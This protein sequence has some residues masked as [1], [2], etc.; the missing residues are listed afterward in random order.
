[1]ERIVV[2]AG[3]IVLS[4]LMVGSA[5][6]T[7]IDAATSPQSP[8]HPDGSGAVQVIPSTVSQSAVG[9]VYDP[10]AQVIP[11][12]T[13][14]SLNPVCGFTGIPSPGCG[15]NPPALAF[16]SATWDNA[17]AD[18]YV[19]LFGGDDKSLNA[20]NG[21]YSWKLG[22]WSTIQVNGQTTS[23]GPAKAYNASIT[24]D[25][26][27]GYVLL[28]GGWKTTS[29]GGPLNQTYSFLSGVWTKRTTP[30]ALTPRSGSCLVWIPTVSGKGGYDLL[31]GGGSATALYS[32][33]WEYSGGTWTNITA[34][35]GSGPSARTN[36]ACAWNPATKKVDLFGGFAGKGDVLNDLW[37]FDP[38][39]GSVGTWSNLIANGTGGSP[40]PRQLASLVY[41]SSSD[42]TTGRMLLLGGGQGNQSFAP[43]QLNGGFSMWDLSGTTWANI[44]ALVGP[45]HAYLT[46]IYGVGSTYAYNYDYGW[47]YG[48]LGGTGNALANTVAEYGLVIKAT[49]SVQPFAPQ[50]NA[51][52]WVNAT[53]SGGTGTYNYNW[54]GYPDGCTGTGNTP[55]ILCVPTV[56]GTYN[57][58]VNITDSAGSPW[59]A[60]VSAPNATLVLPSP[61]PSTIVA[62][63]LSVGGPIGTHPASYFLGAA[64]SPSPVYGYNGGTY[65]AGTYVNS[66]N[67]GFSRVGGGG[68]GYNPI[69]NQ[70]W[71]APSGGGTYV[72]TGSQPYNLTQ[73][74]EWYASLSPT[75]PKQTWIYYLPAEQNNTSFAEYTAIWF[76]TVFGLAPQMWE[77]GNEPNSNPSGDWSHYG[78][79]F[80]AWSTTDDYSTTPQDYATMVKNY[81]IAVHALYPN[82]KF[83]ACECASVSATQL[84][85]LI[86]QDWSYVQAVAYHEYPALGSSSSPYGAIGAYYSSL[87]STGGI[88]NRMTEVRS[89]LTAQCA[90]NPT[91]LAL[92]IQIGEY[93]GGPASNLSTYNGLFQGAVWMAASLT[94]ALDYNVSSFQVFNIGSLTQPVA[95]K[96]AL[97]LPEGMLYQRILANM[98]FGA[99]YQANVTGSGIGTQSNFAI[100]TVN[101]SHTS[102]LVVNTNLTHIIAL[103]DGLSGPGS[104]Y[105]WDPALTVPVVTRYSSL[106]QVYQVPS[107]GVLLINNY[108]GASG[109]SGGGSSGSNPT[110]L[111]VLYVTAST[112]TLAWGASAP[113]SSYLVH[114]GTYCGS[115]VSSELVYGQSATVSDL[116]PFTV[117]CFAVSTTA[118]TVWSGSV[119]VR[120]LVLNIPVLPFKFPPFSPISAVVV[121]AAIGIGALGASVHRSSRY[122][123][124]TLLLIAVALFVWLLFVGA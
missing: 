86:A 40:Q 88:A 64:N 9:S 100:Q 105:L 22:N 90:G 36:A 70:N 120:T 21:T 8:T 65:P 14:P 10:Y 122:A 17:S 1:M 89:I 27:S 72:P 33:D 53:V 83:I 39:G 102:Q 25:G 41:D 77:F 37:A 117:Y 87:T 61:P 46:G 62:A 5:L 50:L 110:N 84:D 28:F 111:T 16:P 34:T 115:L 57:V 63:A 3:V 18:K 19:V 52:I 58:S 23:V 85:P 32:A 91:C 42:S 49:L 95:T 104:T 54:S 15:G 107:Q 119:A 101:G 30:T 113:G 123:G 66:T 55:R 6:P 121:V 97:V 99:T 29:G 44:S 4:A 31:F 75:T 67:I 124:G 12:T 96:T 78:K 76:H 68:L 48:G 45:P 98:T 116:F 74:K 114:Y 112:V 60:Y 11:D 93:N 43:L 106:P 108:G 69:T 109:S 26:T 51:N 79:N 80:S 81:A 2:M 38:T 59:P 7:I 24:Y 82:D 71:V 35:V 118:S 13:N 92:P 20:E 73:F 94:L 47:Y 103:S 56:G